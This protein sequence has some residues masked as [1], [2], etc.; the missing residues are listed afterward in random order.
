[1]PLK[2]PRTE[3]AC[4]PVALINSFNVTPSGRFSKSRILA[5]LLPWRA[6]VAFFAG[7]A[8]RPDLGLDAATE[9]RRLA[10][11]A[12]V[13]AVAGAVLVFS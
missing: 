1:V 11:P 9:A 13:G 4:Q 3:C 5:V 7:G 6:G 10:T 2:K 12:F 8:F